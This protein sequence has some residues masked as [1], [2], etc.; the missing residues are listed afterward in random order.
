MHHDS[1]LPCPSAPSGCSSHSH[2]NLTMPKCST[3]TMHTWSHVGLTWEEVSFEAFLGNCVVWLELYPHVVVLRGDDLGDFRA[4]VFTMQLRVRR[5]AA[6]H[7]D[8]I[9]FTNLKH[10]NGVRRLAPLNP[11]GSNTIAQAHKPRCPPAQ[12][13]QTAWRCG[14]DWEPPPAKHSSCW[15]DIL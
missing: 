15:V 11:Y 13:P 9:V 10:R 4:A 14:T 5:E 2:L 7:L 12:K 3:L 6:P 1:P 8:I